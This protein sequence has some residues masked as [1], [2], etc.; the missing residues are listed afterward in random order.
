MRG[1]GSSTALG[2]ARF[3]LLSIQRLPCFPARAAAATT[4]HKRNDTPPTPPIPT[5]N[6]KTK[7]IVVGRPEL[8]EAARADPSQLSASPGDDGGSSGGDADDSLGGVAVLDIRG[9]FMFDP[10]THRDFL[11]ALVGTGVQR[12]VVGDVLVLGEAGAQALVDASL[13]EHFE[14][15]VTRVRTVP[16]E[17]R[18]VP[19]SELR[20]PPQRV[21]EVSSVEASLRLDAVASAGFRLG[22]GAMQELIKKGDVRVNWRD[23]SKPSVEVKEGDVISVAG[24]GRLEVKAVSKTKKDKFA[25][26]M[27]RLL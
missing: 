18:G 23:A 26:S 27:L 6:A 3:L 1:E 16:V 2:A 22:R 8:L 12:D 14:A 10:A 17:C 9:N 25:V 13:V 4:N 7:R 21:Q 24:R 11:G 19:L 15:S 20:V 5:P